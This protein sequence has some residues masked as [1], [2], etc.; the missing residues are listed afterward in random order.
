MTSKQGKCCGSCKHFTNE[1]ALGL[2]W[3]A[4]L[5]CETTCGGNCNQYE[6][7]NN[8][9]TTEDNRKQMETREIAFRGKDADNDHEWK[10]GSLIVCPDGS[11]VIVCFDDDG[12][13]LSYDVVPAT[14]GQYTGLKDR[15]GKDIYEGDILRMSYRN[16]DLG[17]VK[18]GSEYAA[19]II[20]KEGKLR[21]WY[22]EGKEEVVGNV[23]DNPEL[24]KG[25]QDGQTAE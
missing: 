6:N 16:D 19:F 2:G 3:C 12:C 17:I 7:K 11:P 18:W 23:H 13:E 24:L 14:V 9:K 1:D 22:L 20:K 5:E 15:N 8:Q 25:G 4:R 10:Y 21:W